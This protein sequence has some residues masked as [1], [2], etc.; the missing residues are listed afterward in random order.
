VSG[1]GSGSEHGDF[2][3]ARPPSLPQGRALGCP[4]QRK[5]TNKRKAKCDIDADTCD[6]CGLVMGLLVCSYECHAGALS[7]V[8]SRPQLAPLDILHLNGM[9]Q[10]EHGCTARESHLSKQRHDD[11]LLPLRLMIT[12]LAR[13]RNVVERSIAPSSPR[14]TG[15]LGSFAY[16]V[17]RGAPV[18]I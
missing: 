6:F 17:N 18:F 11:R 13:M 10:A 4:G 5:T 3:P 2:V 16:P 1:A 7:A 8:R 15:E 14:R 12:Q 9:L